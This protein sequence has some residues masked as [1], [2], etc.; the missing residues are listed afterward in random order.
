MFFSPTMYVSCDK[1]L[2]IARDEWQCKYYNLRG[3]AVSFISKEIIQER[4]ALNFDVLLTVLYQ[5]NGFKAPVADCL[6]FVH[7]IDYESVKS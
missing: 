1:I 5:V 6:R 3:S 2:K 4:C 7:I